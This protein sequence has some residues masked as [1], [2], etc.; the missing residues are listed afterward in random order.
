MENK[1]FLINGHAVD[2]VYED[3][4]YDILL[5]GKK[6]HVIIIITCGNCCLF[7]A[8]TEQDYLRD[9]SLDSCISLVNR[10]L[11]FGVNL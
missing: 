2:Y 5:D 10:M 1:S 7:S 6:T 8:N 3:G 11:P 9:V 4:L